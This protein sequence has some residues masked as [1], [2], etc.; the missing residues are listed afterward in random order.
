MNLTDC[1]RGAVQR[2]TSLSPSEWC[3]EHVKLFRST[4]AT[5]YR[6]EY[7]PWWTEPMK[8]IRDNGNK[9]ISITTPVGSGKSTMIEALACNVLSED[10]GPMMISG[11][12]NEDVRDW[13]ETGLW[14]TLAACVPLKTKLPTERGK[15]RKMELIIP[16]API[17]LTG[18]NMSGLQSKSERWVIGDEVWLWKQGMIGEILKR[19]HRRW[20]GR[21]VFLGQAG[22]LHAGEREEVVGDD[23]TLIHHQGEQRVWS[24]SCPKCKDSQPFE[25]E[26]LKYPDEGTAAERS[27]KAVYEC[28]NC[29]TALKDTTKNRRKL[30]E[31][32]KYEITREAH[33]PGHISFHL[34]AFTLWRSPWADIALEHIVAQDAL[35][36]GQSLPMQQFV[37][38]QM[39]KPWD[40]ALTLS[41]EDLDYGEES[42]RSYSGGEKLE[43]EVMRF[44]TIDV[45]KW[46]YW[47]CIRA[48]R[49]DASSVGVYYG[50][51][52]TDEM[53]D[54]VMR[55]HGVQS[56]HAYIDSGYDSTR[57]Y[58]LCARY[59]WV[60][61]KG[62]P[63]GG[64]RHSAAGGGTVLRLMSKRKTVVAPC[65]KRIPLV[66]LAVDQIKNV[67]A[68]LR[69]GEGVPWQVCFDIGDA[70]TEQIDSEE[71]EEFLHPKTKQPTVRWVRKKKHNHAWDCEVYQVAAALIWRVF[72][73]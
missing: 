38:K 42:C 14:P 39:A 23:F 8:E 56:N 19:L 5:N 21:A 20:N 33:L 12:T 10:P 24:F 11:Q 15:W 60:A 44:A 22:F 54:Q 34:N 30:C 69:A 67:L 41:Q 70:W 43:G 49:A 63:S 59:G 72:P 31:R 37:Q 58:D 28:A 6:P 68:R 47:L 36:T 53:L 13:A 18:A 4:D 27:R 52:H 3:R 17:H 7:T 29:S 62:D 57:V 1:Y 73:T 65:G 55:D 48:W 64:F 35:K 25:L 51:I 26:Q 32:S 2:R 46:H 16:R 71:R 61:I 66:H 40:D 50:L 9:V 45:G